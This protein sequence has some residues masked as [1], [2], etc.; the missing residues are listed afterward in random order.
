MKVNLD[1]LKII[2]GTYSQYK[3]EIEILAKEH[4]EET[5]LPGSPE[6]Q[7]ELDS[8]LFKVL[9]DNNL[10]LGLGLKYNNELIG[11]LSI[12]VFDNHQHKGVRFASTDGFFIDRKYRGL[13][14][15]RKLIDLFKEAEY[16]LK[17]EFKVQYF[18]LNANSKKDLKFLA[19]CLRFTK[20][21][22]TYT[23]RI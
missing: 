21:T 7:V 19:Q 1:D 9:E 14:T 20:S 6:L 12:I 11:Y 13:N 8:N 18:S 15:F 3:N 16:I 10:Y 23:K 2:R 4:W 22:I 17:N 5:G